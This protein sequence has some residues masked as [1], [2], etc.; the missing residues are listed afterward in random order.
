MTADGR[1][2]HFKIETRSTKWVSNNIRPGLEEAYFSISSIDQ[3]FRN[4]L[5]S[6]VP[7]RELLRSDSIWILSIIQ[8]L[9]QS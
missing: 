5:L 4:L 6:D 7:L 2:K 1:R 8:S 3:P 9:N